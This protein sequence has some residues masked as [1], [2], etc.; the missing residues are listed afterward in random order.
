MV[1]PG[2]T[3]DLDGGTGTGSGEGSYSY[4][5]IVKEHYARSWD[6]RGATDED[7]TT[8]VKVVIA[9]D[10]K[11]VA[12]HITKSSGNRALD[13]TIQQALNRVPSIRPFE[14]GAREKQR[15]YTINFNARAKRWLE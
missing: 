11:V 5:Q 10:G 13:D 3:I 6:P 15:T 1:S 4:A 12:A 9:S 14:N 2:A 8:V 7:G